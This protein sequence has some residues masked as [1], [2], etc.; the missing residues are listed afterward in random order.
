MKIRILALLFAA[1]TG[2]LLIPMG[3]AEA[4]MYVDTEE[5][6]S[7]LLG[8]FLLITGMVGGLCL[9]FAFM[10]RDSNKI[11]PSLEP[12]SVVVPPAKQES[13]IVPHIITA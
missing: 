2:S 13:N 6:R 10:A 9:I 7:T 3:T 5:R 1:A 4:M 12:S 11:E 8:A